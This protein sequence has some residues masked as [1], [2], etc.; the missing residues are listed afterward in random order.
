MPLNG[1]QRVANWLHSIVIL[2]HKNYKNYKNYKIYKNYKK[3][4]KEK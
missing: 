3:S 1:C 4:A 2:D